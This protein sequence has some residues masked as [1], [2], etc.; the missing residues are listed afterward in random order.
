KSAA[1]SAAQ[2][3]CKVSDER[4]GQR[5]SN[6]TARATTWSVMRMTIEASTSWIS[7]RLFMAYCGGE[8]FP[9]RR[10]L[11]SAE[12]STERPIT[13]RPSDDAA[14]KISPTRSLPTS[15]TYR[16]ASAEESK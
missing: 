12:I 8:S 2:A 6:S 11:H 4:N 13:E 3:T 16:L 14:D 5:S 10:S 9:S 1:H 7:A 15:L